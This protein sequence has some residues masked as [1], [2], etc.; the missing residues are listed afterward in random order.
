MWAS[1]YGISIK[2]SSVLDYF[3]GTNEHTIGMN[4]AYK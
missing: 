4:F 3:I 1:F 2:A